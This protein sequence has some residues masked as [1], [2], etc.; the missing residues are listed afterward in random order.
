M[1]NEGFLKFIR[2]QIE[3]DL[4]TVIQEETADKVSV[5]A[6]SL[7]DEQKK[8]VVQNLAGT[9]LPLGGGTIN[10]RIRT[11]QPNIIGAISNDQYINID[12]G[13]V[14]DN[15]ASLTLYGKDHVTMPGY[16]VVTAKDQNNGAALIAKPSGDL[17]WVGKGIECLN[18]I[19]ENYIRYESGLQICWG[20]TF[21]PGGL[22][23]TTVTL[24]VP[25]KD[26][27]YTAHA[28]YLDVRH[29]TVGATTENGSGTDF[30]VAVTDLGGNYYWDRYFVWSTIGRW[31]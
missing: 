21:V 23:N 29:T 4:V 8:T 27:S 18:A 6:Q 22:I 5:N 17:T 12:G 1:S 2:N 14:Y 7:T 3:K 20:K 26:T 19:G 10:G 25:Y 11:S 30:R 16:V 15:G 31:K 28:S 13:T 9:F 24:P